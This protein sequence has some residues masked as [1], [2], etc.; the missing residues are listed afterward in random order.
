MPGFTPTNTWA[1]ALKYA[2]TSDARQVR[3]ILDFANLIDYD[4]FPF[5]V[6]LG[7]TEIGKEGNKTIKPMISSVDVTTLTPE[8]YDYEVAPTQFRLTT[9]TSAIDVEGTATLTLDTNAGLNVGDIIN[10]IGV[11]AQARI[12]SLTGST[13]CAIVV[14][15]SSQG[16]VVWT[17][18]ASVRYIEKLSNAQIDGY[19]VGQ[20]NNREPTNR[21][22][23]LQFSVIP[24]SQGILQE[25]LRLYAN[26]GEGMDAGFLQEKKFKLQDMQRGREA[27]FIAGR[28]A[29]VSSAA[30]RIYIADGLLGWAGTVYNNTAPGGELSWDAFCRQLMP[31]ARAAGGGMEV[32]GICGNDVATVFTSYQQKQ[33]QVT[34]STEEYKSNVKKI[35]CPGGT[36]N[37]LVSEFMNKEARRGQMITFQPKFMKRAVLRGL[38]LQWVNQ[39]QLGNELAKRAAHLVCECLMVSNPNSVCIHTDIL[40]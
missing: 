20:G 18:D 38:D 37:L 28:K 12:T 23:Y 2:G 35:T 33:I 10:H 4:M 19:Q 3:Q 17:A 8:I 16:S 1:N 29:T 25:K 39:L 9:A 7:G 15:Y 11:D 34:S 13:Q 31:Q 22:N 36:L 40:S 21:S 27:Q 5:M 26:G 32:Y 14:T 30:D 6:L 24:M